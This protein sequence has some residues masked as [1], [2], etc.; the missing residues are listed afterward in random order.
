MREK[1]IGVK[2]G[3]SLRYAERCYPV[4]ELYQIQRK[5]VDLGAFWLY[6]EVQGRGDEWLEIG[7][8]IPSLYVKTRFG[9]YVGWMIE[10][11]FATE[12]NLRFL[13]DVFERLRRTFA[14]HGAQVRILPYKPNIAHL[15]NAALTDN[16]YNLRDD[17]APLLESIP[18]KEKKEELALSTLT[19]F[20]QNSEDALFDAIRFAVYDFVRANSKSAL[21]YE[22]VEEIARIKYEVIGSSKG[23]STAKAKARNIYRWVI[24]N[25]KENAGVNNWNYTPKYKGNPEKEKELLM[26]RRERALTNAQKIKEEKRKIILSIVKGMFAEDYKKKDGTWNISKL[27]R[28]LKMDPKTIRKHIRE[29]KEEGLL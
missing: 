10:G 16:V 3:D 17:I 1:H 12:N 21:T 27:A 23:W 24:E 29:L 6:I 15:T 19:A 18:K 14:L 20:G 5:Y 13:R 4:R 8:P 25:F 22:Y 7:L 28:D 2:F 9:A 11:F 26:T